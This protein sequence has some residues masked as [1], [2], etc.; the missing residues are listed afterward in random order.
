MIQKLSKWGQACSALFLRGRTQAERI[1]QERMRAN[2]VEAAEQCGILSI[3]E[4]APPTRLDA[5]V[6]GWD[7]TRLLIFCDE[8][9]P[10]RDPLERFHAPFRR[11]RTTPAG[12][13]DRPR[14]RLRPG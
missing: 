4:I 13:I 10:V 2:A 5:L 9:A 14:R 12:R 3:P 7:K 11:W 1:N 8:D 6:E